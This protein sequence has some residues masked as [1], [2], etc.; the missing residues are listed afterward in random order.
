[1]DLQ[2]MPQNADHL[3][4]QQPATTRQPDCPRVSHRF[5]LHGNFVRPITGGDWCKLPDPTLPKP[6]P[7]ETATRRPGSRCFQPISLPLKINMLDV[8][9][10][11]FA[12][13]DAVVSSRLLFLPP[14][15]FAVAIHFEASPAL[16]WCRTSHTPTQ[17]TSPHHVMSST[18]IPTQS[19]TVAEA[20]RYVNLF[21]HTPRLHLQCKRHLTQGVE[22]TLRHLLHSTPAR[23]SLMLGHYLATPMQRTELFSLQGSTQGSSSAEI[24]NKT[25]ITEARTQQYLEH[26]DKTWEQAR[27]SGSR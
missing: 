25:K 8:Y 5:T 12:H 1:M 19:T 3:W 26:W 6:R 2:I 18:P 13:P 11:A 9:L 24:K 17:P 10:M 14:S 27:A 21:I 23:P 16:S 4:E 22:L 15:V 20:S 7:P